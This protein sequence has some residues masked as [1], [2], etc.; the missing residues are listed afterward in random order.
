MY[1]PRKIIESKVWIIISIS[2]ATNLYDVSFF[3]YM[4]TSHKRYLQLLLKI[5]WNFKSLVS[6]TFLV[7]HYR[8]NLDNDCLPLYS[9]SSESKRKFLQQRQHIFSKCTPTTHRHDALSSAFAESRKEKPLENFMYL[10]FS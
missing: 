6:I 5:F 9:K 1:S 8:E 7:W 3:T 4:F 2:H 10:E